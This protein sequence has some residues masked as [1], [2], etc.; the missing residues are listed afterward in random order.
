MTETIR[1][2]NP[3]Y[4]PT[5]SLGEDEHGTC[6]LCGF[7]GKLSKT[8][9]PPRAVYNNDKSSKAALVS[10]P[11][12]IKELVLRTAHAGGGVWKYLL[13]KDCNSRLGATTTS[14]SCSPMQ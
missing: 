10:K 9:V 11:D 4:E 6:G 14:G 8:H 7:E 2:R 12:G 3:I 1:P 5:S 13:C